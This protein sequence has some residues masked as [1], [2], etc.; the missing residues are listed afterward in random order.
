M[1]GLTEHISGLK[2]I[3]GTSE[4][5]G[6]AVAVFSNGDAVVV[7]YFRGTVNFGS[8]SAVTSAGNEDIFIAKYAGADGAHQWS[9]RIGDV[10]NDRGCSVAVTVVGMW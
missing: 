4:D 8:S 6:R 3:G 7:G 9:K 1:M 2:R 5:I 10:S